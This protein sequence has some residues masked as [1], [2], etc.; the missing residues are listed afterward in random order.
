MFIAA[1][2]RCFCDIDIWRACRLITE[3]EYDK[4]E[5]WF[6]EDSD[7][8]QPS[9]IAADP[10]RFC[11]QFRERTRLTP[12]AFYLE[13]DVD[14]STLA[15][16]SK[17]AKMMRITQI[18]LPSAPLGTPFNTE[19]DRLSRFVRIASEDGVRLSL[20]TRTGDLTE[21]PRTAVELCQAVRG[22]GLTLDPSY[23][24]CGSNG[25]GEVK[26]ACETVL[27][28]VFHVHLRDSSPEQLQVQIG[29]GTIDYSRLINQLRRQRYDR[30]LSVDL[31]PSLIDGVDRS[32]ELRKLRMLLD[33]LL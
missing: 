4:I 22:L 20:K 5:L 17:L 24:V 27:P 25:N 33:T 12:V 8:L 18:T 9:E 1:S 6:S 7:H 30:V 14:E 3:L 26:S 19:I 21:D 16:L 11:A 23:Y 13:E 31:I 2:T 28:H 15:G 10:E 29:L 32:L